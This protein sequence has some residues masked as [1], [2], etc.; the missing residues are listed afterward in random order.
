MNELILPLSLVMGVLCFALAARWYVLPA[1]DKYSLTD[2]LTALLL[3]HG[4]RYVGLA[5]LVPGV[6]AA[7]L[8]PRFANPAAW[9]D[10]AAAILALLA[11]A[12]LRS[13][14]RYAIPAVLIANLFGL[15][16]LVNAVARGLLYTPDGDLGATWFIPTIIVPL[17]VVTHF[18]IFRQVY[19]ARVRSEEH[20]PD[21]ATASP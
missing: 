5:F 19:R 14:W 1:L 20:L 8:D 12:A 18:V 17:L 2:G 9:G 21:T 3:L 7:P 13:N 15:L 11:I 6:T 10:L 16:D 4:F